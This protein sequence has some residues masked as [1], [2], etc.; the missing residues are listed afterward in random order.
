MRKLLI[1]LI[2]LLIFLASVG[3]GY[4]YLNTRNDQRNSS[5]INENIIQNEIEYIST[6]QTDEI[7]SPN[8]ELIKTIYYNKCGHTMTEEEN[9]SDDLVNLNEEQIKEKYDII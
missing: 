5:K 9:I 2:L 4:F 3:I 1:M 7:V 6:E 8:S